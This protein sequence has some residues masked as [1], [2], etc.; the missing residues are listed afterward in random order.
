M[1]G[2]LGGG[3]GGRQVL[4][5]STAYFV[6]S[7]GNDNNNGLV[8][9][10]SGAWLTLQHAM[11]YIANNLDIAGFTVVV[12]IGAGTFDGFTIITTSGGGIIMFVGAGVGNTII[13][14]DP[15]NTS[16]GCV[17]DFLSCASII[18]IDAVTLDASLAGGTFAGIL[19]QAN[20]EIDV[21]F[22]GGAG[23]TFVAPAFSF[24]ASAN[25]YGSVI[26]VAGGNNIISSTGGGL[27]FGGHGGFI[28]DRGQS[29]TLNGNPTWS[30]ACVVA[31][32]GAIIEPR[33]AITGTA[34]GRRFLVDSG[35][36]DT[37]GQGDTALPGTTQ[38]RVRNGGV[39]L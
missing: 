32:D 26:V 13:T 37:G 28:V 7:D 31:S 18:V 12:N 6:R 4:K 33:I 3:G 20:S 39:Y 34:V 22:L 24:A 19:N 23:V 8:N 38:G 27:F 25:N 35:L 14:R 9:S 15:A 29:W 16:F 36:V 1:S 10:P 5:A 17:T 11:N 30:N 2:F 21:S